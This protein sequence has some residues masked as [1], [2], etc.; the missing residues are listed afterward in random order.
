MTLG[1]ALAFDPFDTTQ[2]WNERPLWQ[3][4]LPLVHLAIVA[5][6]FGLQVGMG[7]R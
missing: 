6:L 3:R 2:A 5:A 1:I 7:D 4:I